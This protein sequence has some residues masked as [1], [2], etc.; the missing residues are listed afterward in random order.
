M[1]HDECGCCAVPKCGDRQSPFRGERAYRALASCFAIQSPN[2]GFRRLSEARLPKRQ[3]P[4]CA[5]SGHL[6]DLDRAAGFGKG[7][8]FRMLASSELGRRAEVGVRKPP[9]NE[10]AVAGEGFAVYGDLIR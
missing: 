5:V 8:G 6:G 3:L 4:V 9:K 1:R 10:P 2:D 7:E